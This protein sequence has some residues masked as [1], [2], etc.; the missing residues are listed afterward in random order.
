MF[1]VL[2]TPHTYCSA[3]VIAFKCTFHKVH[4]QREQ[5][6]LH[7]IR[8]PC[9]LSYFIQNRHLLE[10]LSLNHHLHTNIKGRRSVTMLKTHISEEVGV[11]IKLQISLNFAKV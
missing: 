6:G 1:S 11:M 7:H 10:T 9:S 3:Y 2:S 5:L 4:L 8:L